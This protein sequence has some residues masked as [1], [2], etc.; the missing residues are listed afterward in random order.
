[1]KR[2]LFLAAATLVLTGCIE[3][4]VTITSEPSGALVHLNDVEVGRTPVSVPFTFY[5]KYDVRIEKE[6]FQTLNTTGDVKADWWEAPGPD[7]VAEALPGR[8][9]VD[10]KLHYTLDPLPPVS[11]EA[12]LDHAKQ[13]RAKLARP[14]PGEP[15]APSPYPG[16]AP[17]AANAPAAANT[18]ATATPVDMNKNGN[19]DPRTP[20]V[21]P[22]T[23]AK[24][25]AP[26]T[27]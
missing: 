20:A 21:P 7:L 19:A 26:A 10:V 25:D 4:T 23:P 8:H 5:G 13:M 12:L 16:A 11:P 1:M 2:P 17:G 9:E 27:P 22:S 14:G 15:V 24:P 18:N 3:R 6:G